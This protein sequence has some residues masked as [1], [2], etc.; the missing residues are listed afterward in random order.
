MSLS[1]NLLRIYT[2]PSCSLIVFPTKELNTSLWLALVPSSFTNVPF[3]ALTYSVPSERFSNEY[4]TSSSEFE[5][6]MLLFCSVLDILLVED[7][8]RNV[9]FGVSPYE[10]LMS[11]VTSFIFVKSLNSF[12]F[13]TFLM[14]IVPWKYLFP[15][16][17]IASK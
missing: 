12:P 2:S 17:K 16:L 13:S 9:D 5:Y 4:L 7:V 10:L 1:G 15:I 3:S 8:L 14:F 6:F 11:S